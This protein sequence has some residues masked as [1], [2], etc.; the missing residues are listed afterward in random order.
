LDHQTDDT[1][2]AR[3]DRRAF[4]QTAG[5]F[6]LVVPPTMTLL[7]STSMSSPAI[8]KSG[9]SNCNNGLGNGQD[10]QPPGDPPVNDGPGTGPG[11][12]GGKH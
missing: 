3:E 1:T 7:L 11:Q 10:C 12:P 8:A 9:I 5:R 4:L 6:A 2:A